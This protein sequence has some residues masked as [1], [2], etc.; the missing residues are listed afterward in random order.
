MDIIGIWSCYN[1]LIFPTLDNDQLD[2]IYDVRRN[3]TYRDMVNRDKKRFDAADENGDGRLT[4]DEYAIYLHPEDSPHMRDVV[5]EE[6]LQDMDRN[7]DGFVDKEEYISKCVCVCV[8]VYVCVCVCVVCIDVCV[9]VC[10]VCI[11]V[12]MCVCGLSF[13]VCVTDD[14]WNPEDGE[15]EEPDWVEQERQQFSEH[16]DKNGNGRLE[17]VCTYL[18]RSEF[19]TH[20]DNICV[21]MHSLP[22]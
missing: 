21:Y 3:T 12:H 4:R 6:T 10:V 20:S 18:C 13:L 17:K 9:C 7:R 16:R 11:H 14:L 19:V 1:S 8:C 2:T 22:A 5:I 15:Q